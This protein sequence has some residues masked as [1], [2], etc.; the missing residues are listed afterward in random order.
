MYLEKVPMKTLKENYRN[1]EVKIKPMKY[2]ERAL[3][4]SLALNFIYTN[5]YLSEVQNTKIKT[6]FDAKQKCTVQVTHTKLN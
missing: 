6:C 5:I 3:R 1:G 4:K 2:F